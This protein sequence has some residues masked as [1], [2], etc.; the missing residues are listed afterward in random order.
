VYYLFEKYVVL[1]GHDFHLFGH[2]KVME[3]IFEKEWSPQI[4]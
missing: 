2:G 1:I 3:I 4:C